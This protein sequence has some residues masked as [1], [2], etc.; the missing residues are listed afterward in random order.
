[1]RNT[2]K[3]VLIFQTVEFLKFADQVL[4]LPGDG[5]IKVE[6]GS[7]SLDK[8][9]GQSVLKDSN[10]GTSTS[11]VARQD[12]SESHVIADVSEPENG[13]LLRQEGDIKLYAYYLKSVSMYTLFVWMLVT[14][15]V[16]VLER[17]PGKYSLTNSDRFG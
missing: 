7:T 12:D 1:M 6:A 10:R 5:K 15:I 17:M 16:A 3:V 4:T 11:G 9:A 13:S 2:P 14:A 8:D